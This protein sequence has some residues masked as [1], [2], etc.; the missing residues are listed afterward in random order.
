MLQS[1]VNRRADNQS[2]YFLNFDANNSSGK[3]N[4]V[5]FNDFSVLQ[6]IH[7]LEKHVAT[8]IKKCY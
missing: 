4:L 2:M 8:I 6:R 5:F 7:F 3:T 1:L